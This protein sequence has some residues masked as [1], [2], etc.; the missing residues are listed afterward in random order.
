MQMV[1]PYFS[2][3]DIEKGAKWDNEISKELERSAFGLII[4]TRETLG[5]HWVSFE[6]AAL[7][8][9]V[10]KAR[11]W[12]AKQPIPGFPYLLRGHA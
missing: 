5:S 12:V 9:Q 6:A 11:I 8:K 3:A 4:M 1:K 2:P 7:S 10:D